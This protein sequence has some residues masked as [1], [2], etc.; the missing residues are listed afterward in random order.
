LWD[1]AGTK[2]AEALS[3][4]E[5]ASGWQT[6]PLATPAVLVPGQVYTAANHSTTGRYAVTSGGLAAVRTVGPLSTVANGGSYVYGT[7]FPINTTSTFFGIDL[8][9][10]PSS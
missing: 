10:V 8:V 9:F 5:S 7:T 3:T 2:V 6:V 1:A 4:A